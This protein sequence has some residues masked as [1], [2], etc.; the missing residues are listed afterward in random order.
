V[1]EWNAHTVPDSVRNT[2]NSRPN[3]D[4]GMTLPIGSSSEYTS[5]YQP[6]GNGCGNADGRI[7]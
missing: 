2:A 4:T 7:F 5:R 1:V 3:A 6:L